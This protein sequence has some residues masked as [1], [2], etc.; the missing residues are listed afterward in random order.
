MQRILLTA[1]VVGLLVSVTSASQGQGGSVGGG[2]VTGVV[3][4]ERGDPIAAARVTLTPGEITVGTDRAGSFRLAV[5]RAGEHQLL[6]VAIG[7][8]PERR[9]LTVR[10]ADTV[11]VAMVLRATAL[12]LAGITVSATPTAR[13]PLAVAQPTSTLGGRDLERAMG[14]TLA[15]TLAGQ[16]GVNSRSQG[17]AASMPI[18]RGL[19]GDRIVVLQDGQRA[20]DVA[21]T[22][23]DHAVTIDPLSAREV[24]IVRGPAALLYGSNALGGVVNVIS[25]DI[26]RLIPERR[27][28][29]LSLNGESASEG[30]GTMLEI[31][32]PLGTS[33]ALR[34]RAGARSHGDM[35]LGGGDG[36]VLANTSMRNEHAV[37][38]I[39]HS[40]GTDGGG[41]G[42]VLRR[43]AF[44]Y[45]LPWRERA[46]DGI[47]L[48][49][50]RHE[51]AAR[52]ELPLSG[53]FA[54]VRADATSQWYAHD[55]VGTDGAIATALAL[56]THQ[57]QVLARTAPHGA[58]GEGAI[59]ASVLVRRNGVEGGQALTPPNAS[60]V[61]G[62]FAFQE[63]HLRGVHPVLRG[64][65]MPLGV[66]VERAVLRSE[67]SDRFGEGRHRPF[68]GVSASAGL[69]VPLSR[70]SSLA[71]NV[72]RAVRPPTAED[73]FSRA[74]H[75]GTG[76]FEIGN[77]D[78]RAERTTGIDAIL[79]TEHARLRSQLAVFSSHVSGWIGLYPAGR[80]TVV[81]AGDASKTLP[82]FIVSQRTA[83][84]RGMEGLVERPL[85][86]HLVGTLSGDLVYARDNGGQ[87]LPF[88]PPARIGGAA[89]WDD[90]RLQGGISLRH[91]FGQSSV[92]AGEI[93]TPRYTLVEAHAGIRFTTGARVHSLLLRGEN[94]GNLLYRDPASRVKDFA[95]SA[96]RNVSLAY[97][98]Y[99]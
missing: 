6:V 2:V 10:G 47:R 87:P 94:L 48:R 13:D 96:G 64:V 78:L 7:H 86:A 21:S 49:G 1:R 20:G 32:Q 84:L 76:A 36:R 8:A 66:R 44:E 27:L 38:G 28:S 83:R 50:I 45:G 58:L 95:P 31:T 40:R 97:R 74:G 56:R 29:S 71:L 37:V 92:P 55:E 52:G 99:F 34:V 68:T 98:V 43:Y 18:I 33:T 77:P 75:A 14:A 53:L 46:A 26:P 82:L 23:S 57:V 12:S 17:P 4:D 73:L 91:A 11:H 39:G 93:S 63:L 25:D 79:R 81:H 80:D 5:R 24:E 3:R 42:V 70:Q 61:A 67:T 35:Q 88:M 60:D 65:R 16:P 90:G 19:T 22:A 72:A 41:G 51:V 69:A 89:R 15:H 62:V 9:W 30:G 54:G 85:F 59:G